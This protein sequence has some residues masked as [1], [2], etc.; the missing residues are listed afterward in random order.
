MIPALV[1]ALKRGHIRGAAVDVYPKEPHSNCKDFHTELQN[2]PNTILTPHIGGS[3]EEAQ[4][5]I[6]IEVASAFIKYINNGTSINSV[7]FPQNDLR[8][9]FAEFKGVRVLNVHK[10]VPGVLKVCVPFGAVFIFFSKS[11]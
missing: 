5:T 1:D 2:C 3:T 11:I 10:N 4:F 6:G 8:I 9:L 7:N